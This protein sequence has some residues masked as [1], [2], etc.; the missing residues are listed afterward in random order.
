MFAEAL[1]S[2]EARLALLLITSERV[3]LTGDLE[4]WMPTEDQI[5][6]TAALLNPYISSYIEYLIGCATGK[7]VPEH[8][9]LGDFESFLYLQ[10]DTA[11]LTEDRKWKRIC[12]QVCPQHC[13]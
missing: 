10:G 12:Q 4:E 3:R 6:E 1:H 7:F 5:K 8:N 11:L 2:P 9:D 13:P